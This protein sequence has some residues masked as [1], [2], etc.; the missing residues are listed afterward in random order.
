MEAARPR[1]LL[2]TFAFLFF[3]T[4]VSADTFSRPL[5]IGSTGQDVAALQTILRDQGFY[6]YG[7]IT[8]YYGPATNVA[9]ISYQISNDLE[10]TGSIGPRTRALLNA[11]RSGTD[12]NASPSSLIHATAP[13][14]I[15]RTLRIGMSGSDVR[16]LQTFLID[17][18][19]SLSADLTGKFTFATQKS[20]AAFQRAKN[21]EPVGYLGPRTRALI[22]ESLAKER[23]TSVISSPQS[24]TATPLIP[25]LS[26]PGGG[27]D[28]GSVVVN[29]ERIEIPATLVQEQGEKP[30]AI[31][32]NIAAQ[33]QQSGSVFT[34]PVAQSTNPNPESL[35]VTSPQPGSV[36]ILPGSGFSQ[37]TP[38]PPTQGSG[39]MFNYDTKVMARFDV[40][41]YQTF[42][43]S[44]NVGVVA[45]HSSGV[46][47][48]E[49]SANGGA[50]V[51]VSSPSLNPETGV[52]EYWVTL[53]AADFQ[54][55][56]V[57][58]RAIAFPNTGIPR[59]LQGTI[60]IRT[61]SNTQTTNGEHSMW[62]FAN[63]A[64]SLG[65]TK[66]YVAP[67]TGN[68]ANPGTV[69]AP[70]ATLKKALQ[71]ASTKSGSTVVL[72]EPGT[73][74]PDMEGV[75]NATSVAR[76]ITIEPDPALSRNTV[77]IT[78]TGASDRL[79]LRI[80]KVRFRN[81]TID[82][83]YF[84]YMNEGGLGNVWLDSVF[85][86]PSVFDINDLQFYRGN[87]YVT[88][89]Q[90]K[91]A[92]YG[93]TDAQLV[94]NAVVSGTYDAYQSAQLL[95][96][97]RVTD[98]TLTAEQSAAHHADV[99]QTWGE[100]QNIIV[101]GLTSDPVSSTQI[102]F[103]NQPVAAGAMMRDAAYVDV[104][105]PSTEVSGPPFS[106]FSGSIKNLYLKNFRA[107]QQ[108]LIMRTDLPA[109][110][111][112]HRK[113][114]PDDVVLEDVLFYSISGNGKLYPNTYVEGLA[115][116]NAGVVVSGGGLLAT[117]TQSVAAQS[118]V[119]VVQPT[120]STTSSTAIPA[121][122]ASQ[123]TQEPSANTESAGVTTARL[124]FSFE[125]VPQGSVVIRDRSSSQFAG[126]LVNNPIFGVGKNGAGLT[127][128]G[129]NQGLNLSDVPLS[130]LG[131]TSNNLTVSAWVQ[132]S[133]LASQSPVILAKGATASAPASETF[134]LYLRKFSTRP[135]V[136][137]SDGNI[138]LR[139][140]ATSG[141]ELSVGSWMHVAGVLE[142]RT[143]KIYI[144]GVLAGTA[145]N[146]QFGSIKDAGTRSL[147]IGY[148]AAAT[149]NFMAGTLDEVRIDN[150]AL[151]ATEISQ[152][153]GGSIVQDKRV[154]FATAEVGGQSLQAILESLTQKIKELASTLER[155]I[156]Q[157]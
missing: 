135:V 16:L 23:A 65:A 4:T 37:M 101:Y 87:V 110:G 28:A 60:P 93:F 151:S 129:T 125:A 52:T 131:I 128:N 153:Y 21:L 86:Q 145:S 73:Y 98:M 24:G 59:V 63:A 126:D 1:L 81:L 18:G 40:V 68:D 133:D 122:S 89:S 116:R 113:F 31:P 17:N 74:N 42:N 149:R 54:D 14:L 142:D 118:G 140:A 120:S 107:P 96:N 70:V 36:A 33:I 32:T 124:L 29:Q 141:P 144:N 76:W 100:K 3:A 108:S 146:A 30:I 102:L 61:T 94:R 157:L 6:T 121:Q 97:S 48:V 139:V 92:V 112:I 90:I 82:P 49:F 115:I 34:Q 55:G 10:G 88:N 105:I 85:V 5:R 45:F 62:L 127:L 130:S 137:F 154:L 84:G 47:R 57:E 50:W 148:D 80:D 75:I 2:A 13:A 119:T 109:D 99:L 20:V 150:R 136:D 12:Q 11:L 53:R 7:S 41:P 134:V 67:R 25:H 123:T 114:V 35:L 132:P 117:S 155:R 15:N 111:I 77:T 83:T 78:G 27:G 71:L 38:Q 39:N 104:F 9:V 103:I 147:G 46:N 22:N 79:L 91:N 19:Y 95:L 156:L 51:S 152:L 143:A 56:S 72:V 106:Q 58:V 8:G 69:N 43:T 138:I 66:F 44:I 64:N 26:T